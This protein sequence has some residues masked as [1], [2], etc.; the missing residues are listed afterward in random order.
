M[1]LFCALLLP[2]LGA[3]WTALAGCAAPASGNGTP[4]PFEALFERMPEPQP[5]DWLYVRD[6]PGRSFENYVA[7]RPNRPESGRDKIYVL[8]LGSIA[9]SEPDLLPAMRDFL[10]AFFGLEVVLEDARPIPERAL[11]EKRKQH[12]AAVLLEQ[13]ASSLPADAAACIGLIEYDLYYEELNYVFG[14]GSFGNR[15]GVY[16]I[17]RYRFEY[18]GQ[19]EDITLL[20]RALKVAAHEIGHIFGVH[21]C[22]R[23]RCV[24]NGSNSIVEADGRPLFLCPACLE[25]LRWNLGF[26]PKKRYERLAD[27]YDEHAGFSAEA[28]RARQLAEAIGG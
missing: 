11:N 7:S 16:S 1:R 9:D 18:I 27:F 21:H 25:K 2:V 14:L 24:M 13:L 28:K 23:W 17:A 12:D 20:K 5:G 4:S 10:E 26:D 8:P 19:A 15:T 6:E 3:G 22:R